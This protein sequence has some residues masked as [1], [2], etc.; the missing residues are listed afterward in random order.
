MCFHIGNGRLTK[1]KQRPRETAEQFTP[2]HVSFESPSQTPTKNNHETTTMKDTALLFF[3]LP[4]LTSRCRSWHNA[5][6]FVE[7]IRPA[8]S[9]LSGGHCEEEI[10]AI[11]EEMRIRLLDS[12]SYA[13]PRRG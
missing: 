8:A 13:K 9:G 6:S 12:N 2:V 7:I 5:T 11:D 1:K 4:V 10:I 3:A